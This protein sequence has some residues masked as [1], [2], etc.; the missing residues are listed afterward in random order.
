MRKFVR[1]IV[2]LATTVVMVVSMTACGSETG[3]ENKTYK[4]TINIAVA[5]EAPNLD[6]MKNSTMI[7]RQ[8]TQG[9]IFEKLLTLDADNNPTPELCESYEVNSD[10]TEFTFK[11]RQ[12][13]KFHDGSTMTSA[14]V[15]A[16]M[17]RWFDVY[18][19]AKAVVGTSR[20]EAVDDYTCK[21]T[22]SSP[23]ATLL[24][25]FAAATQPAVITTAKE[26]ENTDSNGFLVNYI[27]T[28]PYKYVEW[29]L[30]E[31]ILLDKFDDYVPYGDA[32]EE[33]N[34]WAGY[35]HAYAK[36]L[37][38][39]YVPEESTRMAGLQTGQ[40]DMDTSISSDN[41]AAV[42]SN[43]DLKATTEEGGIV[44]AI[45][46]KKSGVCSNNDMRKAINAALNCEDLL[47]AY[48]G[49]FYKLDSCYMETFQTAWSN[50]AGSENY[51]IHDMAKVKEYLKA[52]GYNGETVNILTGNI[53]NFDKVAEVMRQ[54]LEAAGIKANVTVV[55]WATFTSLR[56]DPSQF[57]VAI[58][59]FGTVPVPSMKVFF[60]KNYCGWSDEATFQ[61]KL[62]AFNSASSVEAAQKAW[63][64]LQDYAWDY[65]PITSFGHYTQAY[66]Y[67]A[68]MEGVVTKMGF[69][70]W[71]ARVAE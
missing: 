59:S 57:D 65:L 10:Y 43:P 34:G 11:L 36:H 38:Y 4:D 7:V 20:F 24:Y 54:Q 12:G 32:N 28:G 8:I 30:N 14:D 61:S 60:G 68:K 67:T 48:N 9:T 49:N 50:K 6:P 2:A 70:F 56:N 16:S 53:T 71:N 55:D 44:S 21:I 47:K 3:S 23:C 64:D 41:Y 66:G 18:S 33:L 52:A 46:N 40:Y 25:D 19:T 13:V 1:R 42:E 35:K 26:C 27:G 39:Y 5:Q 17:N 31:Y 15:V 37:Y 62:S 29:K 58:T 63:E 45:Y 51:N 22:L 69:Y